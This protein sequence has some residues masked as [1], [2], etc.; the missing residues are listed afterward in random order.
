MKGFISILFALVL[1]LSMSLLPAMPAGA[2]DS[3]T[4]HVS[5]WTEDAANPIFDP[6]AKA[7]YPTVVKVSDSDYRMW[8][9][10]DSGVGYATSTDGLAWTEETNPVSG[11]T[12]AN[13]P[14]VEYYP[15]GFACDGSTCYFRI[16]YWDTG[17]SIYGISVIRYAES[18]DGQNWINDQAITG[19]IITAGD[20]WNRGSYG[21]IDVLYNS[22]ATNTGDNPFDYSFAMYFDGTTGA[23]E[24]IGLGYSPDG[25]AWTLYGKVLPR[26]NDGDWGNTD[27]WDSSYTTF[28]TII[29]EADGKWHMWYSGG[30]VDSNDGIGYA[31]SSDGLDWVRSPNNPIMH[32]NDGVPWRNDRTYCPMVIEDGG[33]YKM[34]FSGKDTAT[35]N[36]AIGYATADGPFP[37]IQSAIDAASAG[38]T[39]NVAAGTYQENVEVDKQLMLQG[40]ARD[41]TIID[42]TALASN[43]VVIGASGVTFSGFTVQNFTSENESENEYE[44]CGI[45]ILD[46]DGCNISDCLVDGNALCGIVIASSEP[47]S[48]ANNS[49]EGNIATLNLCGIA[50][51]SL[52]EA[53]SNNHNNI[54][55]GNQ[56][57]GND[58]GIYIDQWSDRNTIAGNTVQANNEGIWV[59]GDDNSIVGND[60]LDNFPP[61]PPPLPPPRPPRPPIIRDPI[62][63]PPVEPIITRTGIALGETGSG[64]IIHFNNIVGNS[65]EGSGSYGVYNENA[66][67]TVDATLNWWG[68]A[69]G[70]THTSNPGG[71]GDAV[72]DNVDYDPWLGEQYAST[73][74]TGTATGT[75][76]ASSSPDSGA[77][78]NLTSVAESTLP[79]AGKPGGLVFP[80]G[81]FSFN[82]TGIGAGSTVIVTVT[83]PSTVP[84]GTQYWKY[85]ASEGGWIQIPMGDDDG[86]NVVTITLVDGGLG[87]DDGI[88][89][90]TI[91]DQGG[92]GTP[93][94]P[95]PP[96]PPVGGGGGGA[97]VF[98]P[99]ISNLT[100]TPAEGAI[101]GVRIGEIVTI[102]TEVENTGG[103]SGSYTV[104]LKINGVVEEEKTVTLAAHEKKTVTFTVIKEEAGTYKTEVNGL[105]GE[106]I[107]PELPAATFETTKLSIS[108]VKV[109]A[110][111]TVTISILVAET[112]GVSGSYD[113]TLKI[114][115]TV[116]EKQ[117][118]ALGPQQ[119]QTVTFTIA[120]QEAGSY[121]VEVNGLV[122]EFTVEAPSPE[123]PPPPAA[124]AAEPFSYGWLIAVI[125]ALAAIAALALIMA[126]KRAQ[127]VTAT[128]E[129][130][131]PVPRLPSSV[132]KVMLAVAAV[133]ASAFITVTK[134]LQ[135]ATVIEEPSKL[136]PRLL[137]RFS[138]AMLAVATIAASPF[139]IVRKRLQR[140]PV[141]EEPAEV[142]PSLF[143]VGNLKITPNRARPGEIVNVFAEV[144]NTGPVTSSY[145]L[146]LRIKGIAEAIKEITLSPGQSQ[147]VAFMI[148]KDKPGTYGVDLEGL[149][150]SFTVE[151]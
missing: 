123:A 27:D 69:S 145:S 121:R 52:A 62:I 45:G 143:R 147:K 34:W 83:L 129:P 99:A 29:K 144:T 1:V 12:N 44:G 98:S 25:I 37:S 106:F 89:N 9:G 17:V 60:I 61:S 137:S 35:G 67:E 32:Q 86:D 138:K 113:A 136:A 84:V 81:F 71:T 120:N 112:S 101:A 92:P 59:G 68:N 6:E 73:K 119:S 72:S 104:I 118:V 2:Q 18:T 15:G 33:I 63:R 51:V 130:A 11:L 88:A 94:P 128:G 114:N 28:G 76:T 48:C 107:V 108:P 111:E 36:Y 22:T 54:L 122:S 103:R 57:G 58:I 139:T 78:E 4:L 50:I 21:T 115:G 38:D 3:A 40:E 134:R 7:Y 53:S 5:K 117:E 91:V 95:P 77:I 116:V 150:G 55:K 140:A 43:G 124:P 82:V 23:F 66:E 110:G 26:G 102:T 109:K 132:T 85:H 87:D 8:Y 39:I 13:H 97:A 64:N 10:S 30:Q 74:S 16:W 93:P 126:R 46:A 65:P 148:L 125:S 96:P 127:P 79:T 146:V 149:G 56:V 14:H 19:N 90:G 49:I 131:Q 80:H 105:E 24:E 70:P 75:G 142:A 151:S 41:T 141:V 135:P 20:V 47:G 31:H 133:A 42:G 100:I